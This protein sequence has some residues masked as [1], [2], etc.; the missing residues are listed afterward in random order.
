M[1]TLVIYTSQTGFTKRYAEWITEETGADLFELD[2]VKKQGEDFLGR[3]DAILY[4]GWCMAGKVVKS[5]WF[6][7][8]A[9]GL[10]SKRLGV[11]AVG[12]SPN[13]NPDV[14]V[15]M[16]KVLTD[17]QKKYIKVF[18]CQGGIDYD[19]MKGPSRFAMK[20]FSKSLAKSKDEKS[21]EMGEYI[22]R[23]Y[24]IS[25]KKFIEPVVDYLKGEEQ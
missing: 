1:R 21:R 22:S 3:Y 17:E 6:L 25:D 9:A 20:M 5:D 12:A 18:Y 15:A 8:K 11:V 7:S 14:K 10:K 4:A 13:E 24:D 16:N 19:K 23:S 2:K